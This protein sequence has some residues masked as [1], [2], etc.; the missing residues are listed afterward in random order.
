MNG[1]NAG[2][3]ACSGGESDRGGGFEDQPQTPSSQRGGIDWFAACQ[4]AHLVPGLQT[5]CNEL[6]DP[7]NTLN[8]QGNKVLLCY[9]GGLLLALESGILSALGSDQLAWAAGCPK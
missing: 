8:D 4:A 1:Y 9:G 6:V 3:N 5:P 7:D 2:L